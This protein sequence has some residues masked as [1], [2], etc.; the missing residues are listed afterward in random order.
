MLYSVPLG[1]KMKYIQK[2]IE[3]LFVCNALVLTISF[4]SG[5]IFIFII[6]PFFMDISVKEYI[7]PLL[8]LYIIMILHLYIVLNKQK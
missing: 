4:A 3:V 5:L 1:G 2:V 6:H 8:S 7:Y